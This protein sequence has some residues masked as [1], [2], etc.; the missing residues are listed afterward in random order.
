MVFLNFLTFF[1][2]V[3]EF[4]IT[5]WVGTERNDDFYLLSFSAFSNLLW[6]EMKPLWYF[7]N[8]LI[9]FFAIFFEI[10]ITLR[11][12]TKQNDNFLF[13]LFLSLVQPILAGNDAI[14]VL[15]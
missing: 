7:I 4:S 12:R 13:S 1:A 14:L 6:L 11:V 9:F 8:L 10:S 3:F 15:R 2:F 5:R